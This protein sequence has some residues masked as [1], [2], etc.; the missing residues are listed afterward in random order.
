MSEWCQPYLTVCE[1]Q[2]AGK[3]DTQALAGSHRVVF[4]SLSRMAL[5]RIEIFLHPSDPTPLLRPWPTGWKRRAS[6][7]RSRI[8]IDNF[9]NVPLRA[10]HLYTSDFTV[11]FTQLTLYE[12]NWVDGRDGSIIRS[13]RYYFCTSNVVR[14]DT[15]NEESCFL[16]PGAKFVPLKGYF[17]RKYAPFSRGV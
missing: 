5:K 8:G 12:H 7:P 10:P 1:S 11:T 16:F 17:V 14:V 15:D 9:E 13:C 4:H 2:L 6:E 3:H